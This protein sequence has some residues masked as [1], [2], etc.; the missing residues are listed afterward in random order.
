MRNA[1]YARQSIDKK[2]SISIETQLEKARA[3]CDVSDSIEEYIDRGYSGK[4]TK[5][6]RFRQLMEDVGK[7][8]VDR[9]IVYKLDRFS[10][11]ILDFSRAWEILSR[12][13]VEFVSVNEKFDTSTPI[14]K[15]MLYITIV[16]AQMERE[17]TAE[18]VTD[19]YYER[20]SYGSWPG[21]PAPYGYKIGRITDTEGHQSPTL[22]ETDKMKTVEL[23]FSQY[24]RDSISLGELSRYLT[25]ELK[26]PGPGRG[27][28]TNVSLSR[29]L[30]NPVYVQADVDVYAYYQELGVKITN[31]L[32]DFTAEHG[33][34]LVGKREAGSRKQKDFSE[35]VLS[36]GNWRGHISSSVWLQCQ[37]KME[38]NRQIGN[39]GKGR[40]T[41][42]SGLM[43]CAYCS[44]SFRIVVDPKYPERK[45][46][47]CSGRSDNM[48]TRLV[49]WH[50]IEVEE[51]VE[52]ELIEFLKNMPRKETVEE[53][54]VD[55][56][57]KMQL[58]AIE[59]R[60]NNLMENL[61]NEKIST[62]TMEL[63]NEEFGN[64][65]EQR[66][67]ISQQ[68]TDRSKPKKIVYQKINFKELG[69]EE[70]KIV[71]QN[72]IKKVILDEEKCQIIWNV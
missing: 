32:Q 9:V 59:D 43:H 45:T 21:G 55:N 8:L 68:I 25:F 15:A 27:S 5:R 72:Y 49:R 16:F 57:I 66:Q 39:T 10:R 26:E 2:D 61:M 42:L 70:K 14:G 29:L 23:I 13:H 38:K 18:R 51:A 11:S 30:H 22:I 63:V 12:N 46:L 17:T 67:K 31:A 33:G 50:V 65:E 48:C 35:A 1:L 34:I 64:L 36:I 3:E 69:F 53:V 71:A 44:R 56:R 40:Y 47:Y 58:K 4:N 7:G 20:V 28:W 54:E 6:P 19:N 62:L 52:K 37:R 24:A 60:K 41:W